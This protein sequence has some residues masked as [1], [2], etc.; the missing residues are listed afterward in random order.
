MTQFL[1]QNAMKLHEA[2]ST[3]RACTR[4]LM[5]V[6]KKLLFDI[7][8]HKPIFTYQKKSIEYKNPLFFLRVSSFSSFTALS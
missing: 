1:Y 6:E 7:V 2:Q 4:N 5:T 3:I 8:T